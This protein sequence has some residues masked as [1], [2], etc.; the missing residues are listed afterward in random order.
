MAMTMMIMLLVIMMLLLIAISKYNHTWSNALLYNDWDV[1]E[2]YIDHFSCFESCQRGCRYALNGFVGHHQKSSRK[3]SQL[4]RKGRQLKTS[5]QD[6]F[7]PRALQTCRS[8]YQNLH[9]SKDDPRVRTPLHC[10]GKK[11]SPQQ[12]EVLEAW[13]ER[14]AWEISKLGTC[15]NSPLL[16]LLFWNSGTLQKIA[17]SSSSQHKNLMANVF[18]LQLKVSIKHCQR[19]QTQG[20]PSANLCQTTQ[21]LGNHNLQDFQ[22][23]QQ[24]KRAPP[25]RGLSSSTRSGETWEMDHLDWNRINRTGWG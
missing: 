1:C 4:G 12:H 9:M 5:N 13:P 14:F 8:L 3:T 18:G 22:S 24:K 2:M 15:Q 17:C 7:D 20:M 23:A 16:F 10:H 19:Y 11:G 21:D 6:W 25:S